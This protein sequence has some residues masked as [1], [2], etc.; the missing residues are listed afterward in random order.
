MD[1]QYWWQVVGGR[2]RF[3]N[4]VGQCT[5]A[6]CNVRLLALLGLLVANLTTAETYVGRVVRVADGDTIT[7]LDQGHTQHKV[8][9]A[10][11]D[12]PEKRQPF[13]QASRQHLASLVADRTVTVETTKR[14][15]YRREVGKVVVDG[16]DVNLVQLDAGMAWHYK[17]YAYEQPFDDRQAY[18]SAEEAARQAR[19]GL[20]LDTNPTP[21]WD[22]RQ[23]NRRD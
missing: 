11:I 10:G 7:V 14:D 21:P 22:Y 13:G 8:R 1:E 23:Q 12:A 4:W 9:L 18:A 3:A 20:W 16:R 15:R 2:P 5:D 19:R 6:L 17:K